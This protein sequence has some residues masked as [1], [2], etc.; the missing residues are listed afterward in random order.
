[1]THGREVR[2]DPTTGAWVVLSSERVARPLPAR[3]DEPVTAPQDCP[4][5]PGHE[6]A[7]PPTIAR[8]PAAGA[9]VARAFANKYPGLRVEEAA[10]ADGWGPHGRV[11][12]VGA[13]E[14]IVECRE[15][16]RSLH[17]LPV[18]RTEAALLLARDRMADLWQ[19]RR[20]A[21][22]HWFRNRGA[23]AGASQSHPHA[24]IVGMPVVAELLATVCDHL[25]EHHA[26]TGRELLGDLVDHERREGTRLVRDGDVVALCPWAPASPFE[27]WLIPA[28]PSPRFSEASDALV[29]AL[30]RALHETTRR[31]ARELGD[32]A[33]NAV[34]FEAPRHAS[35][36]FRWHVRVRPRVTA[37]AGFELATGGAMHHA[38]PEEAARVLR[39]D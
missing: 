2:R 8:L 23:S 26:R 29:I 13:H 36:G 31:I 28:A 1:V 35:A 22:L 15:H 30:A 18:E 38:F 4:F 24:Q 14:V 20:I 39:A 12:G 34:L 6:G 5:C 7:T 32:P 33:Y 25:A 16:A 27:V 21:A 19:D 37:L 11:R 3:R 9:W 17:D 10:G